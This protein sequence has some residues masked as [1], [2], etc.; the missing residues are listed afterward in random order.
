MKR[1][2]Q[3]AEWTLMDPN[4]CP[5]LDETHG[6]EFEALYEKYERENKGLRT[7]KAQDIWFK[8]LTSQVETGMPYLLYKDSANAKSNQQNLGTIKSSN[9]CTE[10]IEYTSPDEVAVCNLGSLALPQYLKRDAEGT[11]SFDFQDLEEH[12]RRLTRNLDRVIDINF[13]PLPEAK[14]SNMRHRPVGIGVQGLADVF[15]R[16][17]LDYCSPEA[18][19]LDAHIFETIYFAAVSESC[20]IA[21]E[22]EPYP[23]F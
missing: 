15:M 19:E 18:L 14:N 23:S 2:M 5:G 1:V 21:K 3:N 12:T 10:I 22:K 4:A 16:L 20:A 9:L 11:Y 17:Q 13:Y 7:V 8:I 6:E